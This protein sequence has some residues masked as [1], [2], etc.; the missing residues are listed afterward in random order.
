M[1][2]IKIQPAVFV[3]VTSCAHAV[4]ETDPKKSCN[5][6]SE[7]FRAFDAVLALLKD[8]CIVV[9]FDL[10]MLAKDHPDAEPFDVSILLQ[11][12][13][14]LN[15]C[16]QIRSLH[17]TTLIATHPSVCHVYISIRGPISIATYLYLKIL[18]QRANYSQLGNK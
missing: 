18:Q 10:V 8:F 1:L 17:N 16:V 3:S 14:E 12:V 13:S 6:R 9:N 5:A 2:N 15:L 11:R 4:L 7:I